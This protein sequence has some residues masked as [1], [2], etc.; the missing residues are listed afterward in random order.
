VVDPDVGGAVDDDRVVLRVP[1]AGVGVGRV[2]LREA[3]QRGL[4]GEVAQDDVVDALDLQAAALI[5]AFLPTPTMVVLAGTFALIALSWLAA[6]AARSPSG[7]SAGSP[8]R[9][10]SSPQFSGEY[11]SRYASKSYPAAAKDAQPSATGSMTPS[12]LTIFGASPPSFN[13]A[14]NSA[15]LVT[16]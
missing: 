6:E 11:F 1:G 5:P 16:V 4:D 2:P 10:L 8:D 9:S 14:L 7:L 13:A 12:T 3:V 15:Q